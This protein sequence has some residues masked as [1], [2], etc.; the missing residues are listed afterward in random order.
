MLLLVGTSEKVV[1]DGRISGHPVVQAEMTG[2]TQVRDH[3]PT[4]PD[5]K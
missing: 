1:S 4:P 3:S 5:L 2:L